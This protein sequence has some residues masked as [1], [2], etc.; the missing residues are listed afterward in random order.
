MLNI[1]ADQATCSEFD[2]FEEQSRTTHNFDFKNS[3]TM[4]LC[5]TMQLIP[6]AP[7]Y[8]QSSLQATHKTATYIN[9]FKKSCHSMDECQM[10]L[11]SSFFDCNKIVKYDWQVLKLRVQV[12]TT[13]VVVMLCYVMLVGSNSSYQVYECYFSVSSSVC[14]QD[15]RWQQPKDCTSTLKII[16]IKPYEPNMSINIY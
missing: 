3:Q 2:H 13:D 9:R 14:H 1:C 7:L 4:A 10:F 11:F 5:S 12:L 16:L 6:W 15:K 8:H